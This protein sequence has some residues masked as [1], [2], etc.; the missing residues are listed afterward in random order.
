MLHQ[1][2]LA[3]ARSAYRPKLPA[4]LSEASVAR[5]EPA[6]SAPDETIRAQFPNTYGQPAVS[7]VPGTAAASAARMRAT[8]S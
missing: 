5:P 4:S 7:F 1:T 8:K 3:K 6:S 2:A